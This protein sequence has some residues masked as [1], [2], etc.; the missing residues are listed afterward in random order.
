[1]RKHRRMSKKYRKMEIN[2]KADRLDRLVRFCVLFI[3]L[4]VAAILVSFVGT[5]FGWFEGLSK[6]LKGIRLPASSSQSVS[7]PPTSSQNDESSKASSMAQKPVTITILGAGDNLIH[8]GIYQQAKRRTGGNGYDFS[9]VYARIAP[10]VQAADVALVNQETPLAGSV[11]PLSGYPKF[12][13]PVEVGGALEQAGFDV[14][15]H[16]NNHIL[17]QGEAG[18]KATLD[19][20]DTQSAKAIG[21]YRGEEDLQNIRVLETKGVKTAYLSVTE[22]TNGLSLPSSSPYKLLYTNETDKIKQLLTK[23]HTLADVVVVSVHWG[24]ENTASITNKQKEL[25]QNLAD[26]GADAI[27]GNHSHTLQPIEVLTRADGTQ[28]PVVY[29][30]GN[31]VSAQAKGINMIGGLATVQFTKNFEQNSTTFAKVKLTPTVTHYGKNYSEITVY[32]LQDYTEELASQHGVKR[33]TSNFS[34]GYIQQ[35]VQD[36]ID[37]KYLQAG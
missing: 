26:W 7:K 13:S 6:G 23:A 25:A 12:N 28:C 11:A 33:Y 9:P 4:V 15:N 27:F 32:P 5:R 18:V 2:K 29:S 17:D 34:L 14:I 24:N 8:E 37:R 10:I 20:W 22:H 31:L 19:Y 16:A 1:M 35:V 36:S 21:I 30:L 3:I